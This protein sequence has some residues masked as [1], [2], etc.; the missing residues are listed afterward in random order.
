LKTIEEE[1]RWEGKDKEEE[2]EDN[3]ELGNK[4]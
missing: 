2:E 3:N 1:K 4:K